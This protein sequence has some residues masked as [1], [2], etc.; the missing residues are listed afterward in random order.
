MI[1]KRSFEAG[2]RGGE[3]DFS[4]NPAPFRGGGTHFKPR[5][6]P[7]HSSAHIYICSVYARHMFRSHYIID[8]KRR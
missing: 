3:G 4:E 8:I 7:P 5:S 6:T 2:F 1:P